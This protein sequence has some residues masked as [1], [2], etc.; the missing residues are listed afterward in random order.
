[1][2]MI[3]LYNFFVIILFWDKGVLSAKWFRSVNI[4][5]FMIIEA[6]EKVGYTWGENNNVYVNKNKTY[7]NILL[8]S[9]LLFKYGY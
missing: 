7:L 9:Y 6:N 2:N 3:L 5:I 8:G 1:M 4:K